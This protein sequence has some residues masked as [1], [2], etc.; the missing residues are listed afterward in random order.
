MDFKVGDKVR[1][2]NDFCLEN[3][4]NSGKLQS[5]TIGNIYKI[6]EVGREYV[7]LE[8][9]DLG[10]RAPGWLKS[11]FEL[12]EESELTKQLS[13]NIDYL[14]ITRDIVGGF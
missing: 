3:N 10:Q 2:I 4:S 12:I 7:T 1:C 11:R 9:N 14:S 5:I 13:T 8:K 6:V